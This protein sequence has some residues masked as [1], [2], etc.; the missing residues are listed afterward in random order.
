[1]AVATV[2]GGGVV[3][4]TW[5]RKHQI[6]LF[7]ATPRRGCYYELRGWDWPEEAVGGVGLVV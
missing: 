4:C 3:H 2:I 5:C 1:M 7:R 6:H